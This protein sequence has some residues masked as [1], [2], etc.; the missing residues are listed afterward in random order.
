MSSYEKQFKEYMPE[1]YKE[2]KT[3]VPKMPDIRPFES[4]EVKSRITEWDDDNRWLHLLLEY[5]TLNSAKDRGEPDY[6]ALIPI[7]DG[8]SS[9]EVDVPENYEYILENSNNKAMR[10]FVNTYRAISWLEVM[11][12]PSFRIYALKGGYYTWLFKM[13]NLSDE[14]RKEFLI[15]RKIWRPVDFLLKPLVFPNKNLN[16]EKRKLFSFYAEMRK[17]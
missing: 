3:I 14:E 9:Y 16:D 15:M 13:E 1:R 7:A 12:D 6:L 4:Q 17:P 11:T 2:I 8:I 10:F 5:Q